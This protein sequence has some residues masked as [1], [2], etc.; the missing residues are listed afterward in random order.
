MAAE[1]DLAEAQLLL[2]RDSRFTQIKH[3]R[4]IVAP[5]SQQLNRKLNK[6]VQNT[7]IACYDEFILIGDSSGVIRLFDLNSN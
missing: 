1:A 2:T 5:I 7:C 3:I 6:K 4:M